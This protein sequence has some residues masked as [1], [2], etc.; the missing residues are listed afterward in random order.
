[1]EQIAV[2]S[3]SQRI[4]KRTV[5]QIVDISPGDDRGQGSSSSAGPAD[6]DFTGGFSHFSP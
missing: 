2:S 6:E 3:T 4:S 1:M 5:E